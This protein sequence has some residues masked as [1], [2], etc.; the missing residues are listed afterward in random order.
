MTTPSQQRNA[1][2]SMAP[3]DSARAL[4]IAEAITDPWYGCQAL[5]WVA[6]YWPDSGF[7]KIVKRSLRLGSESTDQYRVVASAAWPVRALVEREAMNDLA[8]VIGDLLT[9]APRITPFSS[10]SEALFLLFQAVLPAGRDTWLPVLQALRDAS[11]PMLSWRQRRN[12]HDAVLITWKID[13]AVATQVTKSVGDEKLTTKIAK[14]V[15]KEKW[16]EPR[17]FFWTGD[18]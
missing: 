15:A 1:A 9:R 4:T 8:P 11:V 13:E 5:A 17:R 3:V 16:M 12:L 10:R 18:V 6:R 14:S 7:R 2:I